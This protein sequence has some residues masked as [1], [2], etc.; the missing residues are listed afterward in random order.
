MASI[1]ATADDPLTLGLT[2]REMRRFYDG[3]RLDH[4]LATPPPLHGASVPTTREEAASLR[5]KLEGA[6]GDTTSTRSRPP[7]TAS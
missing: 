3:V 5:A 2:V 1:V 7:R 6:G 4:S